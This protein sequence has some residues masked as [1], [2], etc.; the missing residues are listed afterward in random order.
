MFKIDFENIKQLQSD[1]KTF[2]ARSLPFATK[3]T[4][5]QAAFNARR[6]AQENI[7]NKMVTRNR[8]T[9]QSVKVNQARTLNI[10]RQEAITGSTVDYLE[11]QE[12]GGTKTSK[13]KEGVTIATS[14]SAGQG[15]STKPRTRLPRKINT[16]AKIRLFKR[17][18]RGQS[19]KQK[20]IVAIKQ[21]IEV[22][23]KFVFLDLRKSKGIFRIV[24]GKRRPKIQMVHDMSNKAVTIPRNPWL[25]PAADDTRKLIPGLYLKSL[26]FQARRQGLFK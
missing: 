16:L 2:A 24:G 5:N 22:G 10:S 23:Q 17:S 14:Y 26:Q 21:A 15:R 4:I 12:F 6:L 20:N 9:I 7:K 18:K 19:R 1:L 25:K 8:F 13:G 3:N 11:T